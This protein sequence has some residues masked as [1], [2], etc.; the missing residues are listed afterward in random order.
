MNM[1][2]VD[3][4][5]YSPNDIIERLKRCIDSGVYG[6]DYTI[7]ARDKNED[8]FDRYCI[9]EA[10]RINVLKSLAVEN[11]NGWDYSDNNRYPDD[12]VHFF[13]YP[14]K[15]IPRGIEDA[16]EQTVVLYIKMT[17]TKQSRMLI[18][19]SFHD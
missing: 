14:V 16:E 1:G 6:L 2:T 12:I 9:T 15:L 7:L 13:R 5:G 11:H 10:D 4:D 17:W 18:V 3:P 8:F 19:I